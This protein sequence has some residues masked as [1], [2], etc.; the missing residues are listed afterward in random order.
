VEITA[1][2]DVMIKMTEVVSG[3]TWQ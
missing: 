1:G 2:T 3:V